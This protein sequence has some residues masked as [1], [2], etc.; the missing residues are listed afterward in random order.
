MVEGLQWPAMLE[1][2]PVHPRSLP[3]TAVM[4]ESVIVAILGRASC[5]LWWTVRERICYAL[6]SCGERY[7]AAISTIFNSVPL[8]TPALFLLLLN[9]RCL[10]ASSIDA[11]IN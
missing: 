11:F 8:V 4:W 5:F 9:P 6:G 3:W 2:W 1:P 7:E 10:E